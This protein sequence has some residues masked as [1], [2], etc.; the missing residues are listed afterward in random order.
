M[1]Q[2]LAEL[3]PFESPQH[4]LGAE[5]RSWR[6]LRGYSLARLGSA[7]HISGALLGKVEKAQRW[8]SK[9]LVERCDETLNAAGTLTRLY[10]LAC[11]GFQVGEG[12]RGCSCGSVGRGDQSPV[13]AADPVLYSDALAV[14]VDFEVYRRRRLDAVPDAMSAMTAPDVRSARVRGDTRK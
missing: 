11:T 9:D 7:V 8:P 14:V 4:Y 1:A 3:R 6:L 2:K 10:G 12:F 13:V 5:L